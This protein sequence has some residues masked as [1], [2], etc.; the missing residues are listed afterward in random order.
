MSRSLCFALTV[1]ASTV[2]P[3]AAQAFGPIAA[4]PDAIVVIG[5]FP[6]EIHRGQEA[7]AVAPKPFARPPYVNLGFFE[8][9]ADHGW[10]WPFGL[11]A[12]A[13]NDAPR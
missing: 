10:L 1:A 11:G 12:V 5:P 6:L 4:S 13:G 8:L 3:T 2:A 7:P 9:D